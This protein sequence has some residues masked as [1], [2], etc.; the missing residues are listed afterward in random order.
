[1]RFLSDRGPHE[2][3]GAVLAVVLPESAT[4]LG[5]Q[6]ALSRNLLSEWFS[7]GPYEAGRIGSIMPLH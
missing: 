6:W 4:A 2:D 5:T 1:M 3:L 7:L